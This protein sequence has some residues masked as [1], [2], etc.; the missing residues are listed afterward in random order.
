MVTEAV[1]FESAKDKALGA[2]EE[3]LE[4]VKAEVKVSAKG[5]SIRGGGEV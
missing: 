3:A 5:S 4:G 1:T 2:L